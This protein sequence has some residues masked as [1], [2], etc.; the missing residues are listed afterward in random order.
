MR[1]P[2]LCVLAIG[3][4]ACT[5]ADARVVELSQPDTV[6]RATT[7]GSAPMFA[8][9]PS[10]DEAIAWVS[11]PGGGTD[12]RLYISVNKAEPLEL[13]DTLGPIEAH[14]E[15]P[16]KISYAPDG[17]LDAIYVVSKVV[18]GKRFPL[19]ALRFVRSM[20]A[21][22]TWSAP[23]TVTSD[24]VFGAHNFHA[25][26]V[27]P[28]GVTYVSWL[29]GTG[30][31]SAAW[32]AH[33]SDDGA[34]WTTAVRPDSGEACPCCRTAL[35]TSSDGTIYM[36]WRKVFPGNIRDVV[37]AKS[38][39][40][41]AT[42]STPVRVHADDWHYDGCPHAG[43]S[44]QV[45]ARGML[46]VAWWVGKEGAAGV[47]YA[48]SNDRGTTFSNP[49][50]L[51]VAKFSK[52]AHVQLALGPDSSGRLVAV[53]WDDGTTKSPAVL[54]RTSHDGG[55]TFGPSQTI[56]DA[57]QAGSFPVISLTKKGIAIAWTEKTIAAA[58]KETHSMP[59][60]KDP[61]A[62]MGLNP[63]GTAQVLVRRGTG[64]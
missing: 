24:A 22:K 56:S 63:I 8:V 19:A 45:D 44:L 21:G 7:V 50:A 5:K 35:A 12:G 26:H 47:Y 58:E 33:S 40:A 57:D 38:T 53:T 42:W 16:P 48:H 14:G 11:A 4:T 51:G 34:T 54:L 52:P 6:T 43:P 46:H 37:V 62:V 30:P 29:G 3:V 28:D 25:L 64:S 59:D 49:V 18:P 61:N 36:G 15:S 23:V 9:S 41:G 60:M 39:D 27:A 32:I 55:N 17:A 31:K 2:I 1:I 10:G 20:N 13:K